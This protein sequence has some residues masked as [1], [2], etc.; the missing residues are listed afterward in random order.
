MAETYRIIL[1]DDHKLLRSGLKGILESVAGLEVVGEAGDG[2]ELLKLLGR[3][4]PNLV[5]LDISMP[6]LRGIEAVSRIRHQYP[7]VQVLILTMHNDRSYLHQAIAAGAAGYLLK[8]DAD[9]DLFIA[10]EKIRQGKIYVSPHLAE[11]M[12]DDWA[13]MH[14]GAV[15]SSVRSGVLTPREKEVLKL[16]AEGKTS[17]EIGELLFI[18]VRTVERHR[19]NIMDRLEIRN[20]ADLVRY[21][22]QEGYI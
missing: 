6:N 8:E 20:T 9:P 18:S 12:L 17:R 4:T 15:N 10:I 11:D 2:L 7:E 16:I 13:G 3:I 5:I 1:A 14:R 19:A 22:M 21:A